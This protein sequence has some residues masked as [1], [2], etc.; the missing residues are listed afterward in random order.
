MARAFGSLDVP[1][2][3][4]KPRERGLTMLIDWG[5]GRR[6]TE[7]FLEV[8]APFADLA[9]V[10]VGI[11]G[12]VEET[13]LRDKLALY[14][15]H[16]VEPFPGGMFLERAWWQGQAR[17]YLRECATVGYRTIEVSDNVL[18]FP[19]GAK[20]ALIR[21]AR[22]AF[23]L[24]VLGE[25][26]RKREVTPFAELVA[27]IEA[28]LSEGCWKVL[29]E[30]AEFFEGG[31]LREP[32]VRDLARAVP[33]DALIFELPGRWI[34]DVHACQ[35][36]EMAVFLV[37]ALGPE[38]NV[39]NVLPDDLVLLETLRTNLGPAMKLPPR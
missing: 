37:E 36:H 8:A 6:V 17:D 14:R 20:E 24:R 39:G 16:Q 33:V 18:R 11:S 2:R 29:V 34:H 3:P 23:G 32:L 13:W 10:A 28:A 9:K 5:L 22:E 21:E 7:D 4:A 12:L 26:G 27:G 15:R 30:A 31:R 1:G 25:V 38:V 19:P 35:V